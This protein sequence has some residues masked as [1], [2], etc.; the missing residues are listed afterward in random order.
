MRT[1]YTL[2][3]LL[4]LV[5]SLALMGCAAPQKQLYPWGSYQA[6]LYEYLKGNGADPGSQI[7]RLEAEAQKN[8]ASGLVSPPGLHGHLGLLYAKVGDDAN[9]VKHLE[10]ERKLFPESATYVDFLLKNAGKSA[11][12]VMKVPS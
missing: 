11:P 4:V 5:L 1:T 7:A 10:A 9:A 6:A 8:A 3:S 12:K 2:G